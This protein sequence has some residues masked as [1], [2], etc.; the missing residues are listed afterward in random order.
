[1]RGDRGREACDLGFRR[2]KPEDLGSSERTRD[3]KARRSYGSG[4][5]MRGNARWS[6]RSFCLGRSNAE[7]LGPGEWRSPR[8]LERPHRG[9]DSVRSDGRRSTPRLG[10]SGPDSKG[11]GPR[12]VC[13][14]S[15]APRRCSLL[16]GRQQWEYYCRGGLHRWCMVSRLMRLIANAVRALMDGYPHIACIGTGLPILV[17][18]LAK[19]IDEIHRVT[20]EVLGEAGIS[21][22]LR[23]IEFRTLTLPSAPSSSRQAARSPTQRQAVPRR[24]RGPGVSTDSGGRSCR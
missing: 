1:M 24:A 4:M 14:P 11:L 2:P 5:G 18:I 3:R 8:D 15:H 7:R 23:V 21:D 16:Y 20:G 22:R 9:G 10:I 12:D 6:A 19:R 13:M 17:A